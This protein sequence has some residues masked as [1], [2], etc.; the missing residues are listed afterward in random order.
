MMSS[1]LA[2]KWL[3]A[4]LNRGIHTLKTVT[5]PSQTSIRHYVSTIEMVLKTA[6]KTGLRR[7][8]YT[9]AETITQLVSDIPI[10]ESSSPSVRVRKLFRYLSENL[11]FAV[12]A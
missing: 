6:I 9:T 5:S 10:R 1:I 2:G 12:Y 7:Y 4:T 3:A 8:A 11:T